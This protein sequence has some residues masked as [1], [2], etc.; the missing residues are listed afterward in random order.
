MLT[1]A[2]KQNGKLATVNNFNEVQFTNK[3]KL[4]TPCIK[5]VGKLLD[6]GYFNNHLVKCFWIFLDRQVNVHIVIFL[7]YIQTSLVLI[8][9]GLGFILTSDIL[10]WSWAIP[11]NVDI[12]CVVNSGSL[13]YNV[14]K[15]DCTIL[16]NGHDII[17]S[18][19]TT[20]N[21]IILIIFSYIFRC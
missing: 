10:A 15:T 13:W 14:G 19:Y 18:P 20:T 16:L 17:L 9:W 6:F 2:P 7:Q 1:V 11:N 12:R 21:K 8:M 5:F 4:K 3:V